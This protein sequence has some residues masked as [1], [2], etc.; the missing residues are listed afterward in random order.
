LGTGAVVLSQNSSASV[1]FALPLLSAVRADSAATAL[2]ALPLLSAVLAEGAATAFFALRLHS[3][4]RADSG[5]G[6]KKMDSLFFFL[7]S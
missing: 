1:F 2:F 6:A 4:V 3:V 7:A 5:R